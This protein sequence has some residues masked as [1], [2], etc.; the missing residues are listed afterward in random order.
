MCITCRNRRDIVDIHGN[1]R[2]TVQRPDC[3]VTV[4]RK[5]KTVP[6]RDRGHIGQAADLPWNRPKGPD[7]AVTAERD[8]VV[9]CGGNRNDVVKPFNLVRPAIFFTYDRRT[10]MGLLPI[11]FLMAIKSRATSE[12]DG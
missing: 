1:R 10:R 7:S 12:G 2:P 4:Q 5:K 9:R 6:G 3:A 8:A 11:R